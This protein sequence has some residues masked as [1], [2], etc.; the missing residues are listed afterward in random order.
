M[1]Q[2]IFHNHQHRVIICRQH[3]CAILPTGVWRHFQNYHKAVPVEVRKGIE[4]RVKQLDLLPPSE[5]V[6]PDNNTM[7]KG[8]EIVKGFRCLYKECNKLRGTIKSIQRHCCS[9]KWIN[10]EEPRWIEQ[11]IQTFFQDKHKRYITTYDCLIE[12]TLQLA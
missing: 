6:L 2:Y 12:V 8:L 11:T 9:H 3:H 1:D 5:V 4:E 10:S 7:V